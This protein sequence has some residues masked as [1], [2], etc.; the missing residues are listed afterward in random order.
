[1]PL[2]EAFFFKS[3]FKADPTALACINIR[4]RLS[5]ITLLSIILKNLSVF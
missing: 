3:Y 4:D 2:I 5:I 1:M